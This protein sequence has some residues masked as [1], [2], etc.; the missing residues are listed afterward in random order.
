VP[1]RDLQGA[2]G[3]RSD[4]HHLATVLGDVDEASRAG[5]FGTETADIDVAVAMAL[6]EAQH[7]KIEAAAVEIQ[8]AFEADQDIIG[9]AQPH[10]AAPKV[11]TH[12]R[13]SASNRTQCD[14]FHSKNWRRISACI[15]DRSHRLHLECRRLWSRIKALMKWFRT[16]RGFVRL[17]VGLFLVAQLAGVVPSPRAHAQAIPNRL[18]LHVHHQH[19]H[20]QHGG[21]KAHHH[22][23]NQSGALGDHCCAL[24][25]FFAGIIPPEVAIDPVSFVGR[26]LAAGAGDRNL[27]IPPGRL[28]R[29][30]RP[31]RY[32]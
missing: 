3:K 11:R 6:G 25:A 19:A 9:R 14:R 8:H 30:P 10:R 16:I 27:G 29:P 4:K 12:P 18:V 7:G 2:G 31:L 13:R 17:L 23:S 1:V 21:N 28:D 15:D 32:T 5:Q 22:D 26:R 20:D 24:H